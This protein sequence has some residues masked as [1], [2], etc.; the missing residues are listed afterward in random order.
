MSN[1]RFRFCCPKCGKNIK[2][3]D[4]LCPHCGVNLDA[5]LE[6]EERQALAQ[7]YLEDAQEAVDSGRNMQEA[8][9]NCDQ[10]IEYIPQSAEAHN[11]RG[12]ILDAMGKTAEAILAYRE[13]VRLDPGLIDA[14]ANLADAEAEY[15]NNPPPPIQASNLTKGKA[16]LLGLLSAWVFFYVIVGNAIYFIVFPLDN[17]TFAGNLQPDQ[18]PIFFGVGV[19]IMVVTILIFFALLSYYTYHINKF[20]TLSANKKGLWSA[21]LYISFGLAMPIYWYLYIWKPLKSNASA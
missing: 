4:V 2:D 5:P 13:A 16:I 11:L 6:K 20:T 15:G 19:P 10:A 14:K 7:P 21:A 3:T 9:D 18:V 17:P 12:V 1:L 8:L